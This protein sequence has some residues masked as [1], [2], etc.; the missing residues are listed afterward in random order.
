MRYEMDIQGYRPSPR[1]SLGE[2]FS[3]SSVNGDT[4]SFNNYFM[5]KNGSPFFPVSGEFHY[6]RMD[7]R[8]WEDELIKMR[9]GGINVVST[10]LFWNHIEEEEGA[11]DF[12]GR[13]DLRRFVELCGKHGLYVIL[14]VGPF[15]H[16][17]VR[18]GGLPDWLYGKPFE[19]R[20]THPDFLKYVRRLYA[21]IGE[22]TQGL[23]FKDNGPIIG[24]QLDNE[25]MHSS[26]AWEI[27]T[28]ISN[29]WVFVGGEG[30]KYILAL[31]KI[32]LD[33][34]LVPAFFTGTAW[35]GAAYSPRVLPLWGGY[36]YRPWIFYSHKGEHPATE[37][38]IYQ[39]Y[40]RDGVKCTDDFEPA[41]QPSER[42]YACCEMGGGMMCCYYYRF[43]Y[44]FKSVDALANI[45]LGSG[46]NWLGYY[47]FQGG[48]NPISK[49][50]TYLNEAQVPKI[51]YDYQAALGEFGQI[52][53]SYSR[54]KAIHFFTRFFGDRIAPMETALP[55]GA[56]Q[57]DPE[58][59]DTLR[60]AV[61]TD[62]ESGF[63]FINNF[64]DHRLMP[65][66]R[67]QVEIKTAKETYRFDISIASEENA[68]LPFH[69][70]L[71][72]ILLQQ[73]NAQPVLKTEING[74]PVYV[75]MAPDGMD[76]S[77]RF[78]EEAEVTCSKP[79]FTVQ[80]ND[81]AVNILLLTR[82]EAD[83]L[84]ILRDGSL[85]LTDAAL[86]EDE[87]GALR[88]E[89]VK[90]ENTLYCYPA[91]RLQGNAR[92]IADDGPW[93]VYQA[94]TAEKQIPVVCEEAAPCRWKLHVPENALDGLKDALLQIDYQGDI[95]MLFLNG[96]MISDNFCNGGTWEVGLMEHKDKMPGAMVLKISPIREGANVN[97]ESAMAARSEKVS[98]LIAEL[99]SIRAQPVYE[100]K[101]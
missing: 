98:A 87:T 6:S 60:F 72:G 29:E 41:Y 66:K 22:Q 49:N 36:A 92:R 86:L 68:I 27:T 16:G 28:G 10:Y 38:Y 3:G 64:Q 90:A 40:H 88:L 37:E 7:D 99:K 20:T 46:C 11:F 79:F 39:D 93:G 69:F 43:E 54:L 67:E 1:Y 47:M 81:K 4:I 56:S 75:F 21:K 55:E 57:I 5:E 44:P 61:R 53:E 33:C 96:V 24:V 17:E 100:V 14:R 15:D 82:E 83:R 31:R 94:A 84:F 8:R 35:G 58:N 18:N 34:G 45:K 12:S 42:P 74:R 85:I 73:A 30:E 51:S 91:D 63:L 52:R 97:V 19:V 65:E 50:G 89:T 48:T 13:R 9:M 59:L 32:A 71:D 95:G 78:E 101:L 2:D 25:Y 26:A 70:D 80:K 23:F 76:G 62:G 77:F